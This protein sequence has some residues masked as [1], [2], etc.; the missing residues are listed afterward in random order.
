MIPAGTEFAILA[1]AR[2]CTNTHKAGDRFTAKTAETITGTEGA[3]IASGADAVVQVVE[4]VAGENDKSKV[5]LTFRVVSLESGGRS[6]T[7]DNA[8]VVTAPVERV[9]RQSTGD[10][11]K[12]VVAGAAIGAVVGR[13]VGGSTRGAV[14]GAAMGTAAG[15][16]AAAGTADYD[17]CVA[18]SARM[19]VRLT[20]AL[21]VR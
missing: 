9:R 8:P 18:A 21:A 11:A 12:K 5:T 16:V 4:S 7:I 15:A 19:T 6:Y 10:Q 2:L 17:G 14:A 3:S 20:E 1:P 13:V